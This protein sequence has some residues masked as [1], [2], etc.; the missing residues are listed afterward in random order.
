[1]FFYNFKK[2]QN[3]VPLLTI[4]EAQIDLKTTIISL[5]LWI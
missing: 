1:M 4:F 3:L 5:Y 2:P